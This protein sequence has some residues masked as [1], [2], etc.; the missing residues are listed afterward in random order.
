[1]SDDDRTVDADPAT[2]DTIRRLAARAEANA[3][4]AAN[5][6]PN[7]A[8]VDLSDV[9]QADRTIDADPD[10]LDQIRLLAQGATRTA[11]AE[12]PGP[13]T[14]SYPPPP[15]SNLASPRSLEEFDVPSGRKVPPPPPV[16]NAAD[17]P[18]RPPARSMRPTD[19][20][21][22]TDDGTRKWRLATAVMAILVAVLLGWM[23]LGGNDNEPAI[24]PT[25]TTVPSGTPITGAPGEGGS[26]G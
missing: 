18:W 22:P 13:P 26:G 2:L 9:D 6:S 17:G 24:D 10:T 11:P 8:G 14:N 20:D 15:L 16:R 4:R 19:D 25:G 7:H 1:M 23:L 12:Q 3:A 5:D 21:R